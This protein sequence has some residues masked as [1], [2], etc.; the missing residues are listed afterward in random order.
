MASLFFYGYWNISYLPLIIASIV[1]NYFISRLIVNAEGCVAGV[2]LKKIYLI[3][4]LILNI[5]L[6]GYFKYLDFMIANINYVLGVD[7]DLYYLALPLAISFFTLQQIAYIV[8][9]YD[10]VVKDRSFINYTF[11]VVFFPQL[12]AGPIVHHK[13]VICQFDDIKNSRLNSDNIKLGVFIFSIGLF[14]KVVLAD[15]LAVWNDTG[16]SNAEFLSVLSAWFL[17]VSYTLQLYFDFSGYTDMAVGLALLFNIKIPHNFNSPFLSSSIVEF[18][19]RWHITLTNFITAYIYN[20]LLRS[21]KKVSFLWAMLAI[22]ITMQIAGIW[23]GAEWKYVLFGA[24]HGLALVLNHVFKKT[25]YKLYRPVGWCLTFIFV[26]ITFTIFRGDDLSQSMSVIGRMFS[27]GSF[28]GYGD[29][30]ILYDEVKIFAILLLLLIIVQKN[31]VL[32]F[33]NNKISNGYVA[34]LLFLVSLYQLN[35]LAILD[36]YEVKFIYFNF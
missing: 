2:S 30:L 11:F 31:N 7:Y 16:F 4:G 8:D 10:G 25:K 19:S 33:F 5:S 17:S 27:L 36:S 32:Y 28:E 35:Y 1:L 15:T 14:K 22:F 26:S 18:W 12:I 23:H 9:S 13:E 29:L 20:P 24:L 6:L 34:F 3:F 21:R